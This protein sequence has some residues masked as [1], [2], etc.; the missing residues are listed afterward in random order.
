MLL[1]LFFPAFVFSQEGGIAPGTNLDRILNKPQ[2]ISS[3]VEGKTF[4]DN[5][6][7]ISA[8]ADVHIVIDKPFQLTSAQAKDLEDY[9]RVFKWFKEVDVTRTGEDIFFQF[10]VSVGAFGMFVNTLNTMRVIEAVDTSDRLRMDYSW[11]SGDGM[12][13]PDYRGQWYFESVTVKGISGTYIRYTAHGAVIRKYP[14]Q[15]TIMR[16]FVNSVHFEVMRQFMKAV[17]T[18]Q[19]AS[20]SPVPGNRFVLYRPGW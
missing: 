16:M 10:M 7:W 9:S 4:D 6:Q 1:L 12:L 19:T 13:Y 11:Y 17:N 8:D 5:S 20:G 3:A 18:R 2:M 14:F 15:E